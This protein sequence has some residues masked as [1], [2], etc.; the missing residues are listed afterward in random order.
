MIFMVWFLAAL[1]SVAPLFGW[2]DPLFLQRIEEEKNCLV[3]QDM[4][5]QIFATCA[6]FYV[7]L[8]FILLLYWKIWKAARHRIRHRVGK[9]QKTTTNN[10]IA[11][12]PTPSK[13]PSGSSMGNLETTPPTTLA[14]FRSPAGPEEQEPKQIGK[15]TTFSDELSCHT[16]TVDT[17]TDSVGSPQGAEDQ[18]METIPQSMSTTVAVID[19]EQ[20]AIPLTISCVSS[21]PPNGENNSVHKKQSSSTEGPKQ[22]LSAPSQTLQVPGSESCC[23]SPSKAKMPRKSKEQKK[24]ETLEAKRERK[25]AT[26]LAIITGA[27]VICWLP[28]FIMALGLAV[29][30]SCLLPDYVI[31]AF[32]WL[33][34][35]N[36]SINPV[37]YTVNPAFRQAF[38]KILC[39]HR[40]PR[41]W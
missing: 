31:S 2:K 25:A 12:T 7:P 13:M 39:G 41:R 35:V 40:Q 8:F 28:F 11:A 36:S 22:L 6:T 21:P 23:A 32:Q 33:G 3:S 38:K 5:Y 37:L 15:S 1:V 27:F 10:S 29:C 18:E 4:G 9:I 26:T 14:P 30:Q 16:G 17:S 20:A 24:K 19:V 34:Y